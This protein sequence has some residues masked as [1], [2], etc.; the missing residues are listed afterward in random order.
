MNSAQE[1]SSAHLSAAS[2]PSASACGDAASGDYEATL[3]W[4]AKLAA[5]A[6]LEDRVFAGVL[7]K[8]R[9]G[10][11]LPWRR[12]AAARTW[13]RGAAAAAIVLVVGGGGWGVYS[14]VEQGQPARV[15]AMPP[16]VLQPGG[17]SSAGVIRAPQTIPGPMVRKPEKAAAAQ[18]QDSAKTHGQRAVTPMRHKRPTA[19]RLAAPNSLW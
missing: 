18:A 8:P 11:V 13:M 19:A 17:F 15:I 7:A 3:R 2:T 12:Q 1:N 10:R 6:G 16:R 9:A 4:I 5:P 14:R